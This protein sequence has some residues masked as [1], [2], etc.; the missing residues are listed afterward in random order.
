MDDDGKPIGGEARFLGSGEL[1]FPIYRVIKG[2]A[3]L[4]TGQVWRRYDEIRFD[5]IQV[6]V[7]PGILVMTP[8]GP[9]RLDYATLLTEP[10]PGRPRHQLQF[11]IGHPF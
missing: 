6:A 1:R 10:L 9:V 11:A 5:E 4:D 8:V 7:G 2:S 3:F